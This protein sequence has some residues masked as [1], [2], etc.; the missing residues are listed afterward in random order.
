MPCFHANFLLLKET[1][2]ISFQILGASSAFFTACSHCH[3]NESRDHSEVARSQGRPA[4]KHQQLPQSLCQ[5]AH[6]CQVLYCNKM[7]QQHSEKI[8]KQSFKK[9]IKKIIVFL[10]TSCLLSINFIKC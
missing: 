4:G 5:K 3:G 10:T 1:V 9:A 2:D 6:Q 7:Y 8:W